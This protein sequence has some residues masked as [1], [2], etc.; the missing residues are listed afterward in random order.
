MWL[1]SFNSLWGCASLVSHLVGLLSWY[2]LPG[3]LFQL[4]LVD[5]NISFWKSPSPFLLSLSFPLFASP[6]I[7]QGNLYFP[8]MARKSG[9]GNKILEKLGH[10]VFSLNSLTPSLSHFFFLFSVR[11]CLVPLFQTHSAFPLSCQPSQP[12]ECFCGVLWPA[13]NVA[14]VTLLLGAVGEGVGCPWQARSRERKAVELPISSLLHPPHH[15][16]SRK[17]ERGWG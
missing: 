10:C 12:V 14:A 17:G 9:S 15:P 5:N 4:F 13:L 16:A 3:F 2:I 11:S 1:V 6:S 7:C 8:V